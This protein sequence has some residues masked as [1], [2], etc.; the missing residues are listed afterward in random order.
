MKNFIMSSLMTLTSQ[1]YQE[2][3]KHWPQIFWNVTWAVDRGDNVRGLV[4]RLLEPSEKNNEHTI[5]KRQATHLV[6]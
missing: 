2:T 6:Y 4:D 3:S 5:I 1:D